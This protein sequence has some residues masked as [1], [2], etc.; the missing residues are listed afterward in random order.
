MSRIKVGLAA[1][2]I[3]A[4]AV[5]LVP[6]VS[7]GGPGKLVDKAVVYINVDSGAF[8]NGYL[9]IEYHSQLFCTTWPYANIV[10]SPR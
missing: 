9:W 10:F 3:G 2:A 1:L 7:S 8:G 6:A 5:A 4:V